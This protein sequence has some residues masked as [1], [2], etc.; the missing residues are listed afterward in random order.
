MY[1]VIFVWVVYAYAYVV[2]RECTPP[3]L[4]GCRI[5]VEYMCMCM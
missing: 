1:A 5:D 3:T 4:G 2:L